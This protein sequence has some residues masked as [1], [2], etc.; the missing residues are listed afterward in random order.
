MLRKQNFV[1]K[2]IRI[3]VRKNYFG[4]FIVSILTIISTLFSSYSY[5]KA[6]SLSLEGDIVAEILSPTA[7]V[8][9]I[10]IDFDGD[11]EMCSMILPV[12]ESGSITLKAN[13]TTTCS[14]P[15]DGDCYCY[16]GD[17]Y[18]RADFRVTDFDGESSFTLTYTNGAL[19]NSYGYT[20]TL[21]VND[22]GIGNPSSVSDTNR[23]YVGAKISISSF[24][25]GTREGNYQSH[26]IGAGRGTPWKMQFNY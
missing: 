23:H 4:Y 21:D 12:G 2:L 18:T 22:S 10:T 20:V 19:E 6:R 17:S 16:G 9:A 26:S 25:G 3:K 7:S 14:V 11:I 15:S 8:A 24:A 1:K 5:K 13:N